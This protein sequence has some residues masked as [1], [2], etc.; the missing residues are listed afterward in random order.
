MTPPG[1]CFMVSHRSMLRHQSRKKFLLAFLIPLALGACRKAPGWQQTTLLYFDTVCEIKLWCTGA[2]FNAS[3]K[4]IEQ[5]FGFIEEF[6][7]PDVNR[8]DSPE[9]NALFDTALAVYH[10][11]AG[12]FDIT[13]APL[14]ALWGF[15]SGEHRVPEPQE[16]T[17]VLN[18]IGMDKVVKENSRIRLPAGMALD[19]GG[20]AK[21]Y[22]IDLAFRALQ[23][24][25]IQHGFINAGGD[26]FCWG[27]NP[28][29]GSWRIGIKH[30]R[31]SGFL[32]ILDIS[33]VGVA[34]T[35]DY[36]RFFMH[37]NIRYHHV[38]DPHTGYPAR[39]KQSVTVIGPEACIC[40]ALST[41]LFV[42]QDPAAILAEYPEYGAVIVA[43]DGKIYRAGKAYPFSPG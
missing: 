11:S 6:F 43:A 37:E 23:R 20:I 7:S 16:I 9:V 40:D 13:I 18:S 24:A 35:G 1:S 10:N 14:A 27:K 19:W 8:L 12:N 21:G 26:L 5:V 31:E 29:A 3:Q 15:R 38:F 22:G 30:P 4:T 36:Q 33:G 28:S 25:G 2:E 32:G 17:S 42:A 41:A 39:G 34:T